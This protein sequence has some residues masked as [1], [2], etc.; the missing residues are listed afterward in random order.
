MSDE[1]TPSVEAEPTQEPVEPA[2]ASPFDDPEME[3]FQGEDTRSGEG[4][5]TL[6]E[7]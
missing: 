3:H 7:D 2:E 5:I 4:F 6:D 1:D